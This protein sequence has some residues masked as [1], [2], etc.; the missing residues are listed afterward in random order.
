[1]T[2]EKKEGFFALFRFY[3]FIIL[4]KLGKFL[5]SK[6]LNNKNPYLLL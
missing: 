2:I 6:V 5:G 4:G 1:M 3:I